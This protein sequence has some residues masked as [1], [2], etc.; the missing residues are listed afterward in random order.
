LL[1]Q[2]LLSFALLGAEWVLWLLVSL[3]IV[4]VA[5]AIE[6]AI[7][8]SLN[9]TA[10]VPL[11]KALAAFLKGG[12]AQDLV[13]ALAGLKGIEARVLQAGM[14]AAA[15]GGPEAAEEAIA[16]TIIF[17]RM[18]LERGL[19]I[20]GTVGANAPFIGLFGT[21]LGIIRAFHELGQSVA[22]AGAAVMSGISAALVATAVGLMVAIPAVVLYNTF[23]RR[24]KDLL[25][26]VESIAH[27]VLARV[28]S[29]PAD[30]D[31]ETIEPRR[32]HSVGGV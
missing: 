20:L 3:S 1:G 11:E 12:S 19:I 16:G 13:Q 22:D 21:V 15:E 7:F 5:I 17:E 18:R 6:R 4:C 10:K 27:L 14:D 2:K 28:K 9:R 8:A 31:H 29:L 25:A 26:R 30:D 32:P 24:N 23:Q